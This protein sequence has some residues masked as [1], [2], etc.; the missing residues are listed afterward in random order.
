MEIDTYH[1]EHTR[2]HIF[3][4]YTLIIKKNFNLNLI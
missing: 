1:F 2:L 4:C 3:I